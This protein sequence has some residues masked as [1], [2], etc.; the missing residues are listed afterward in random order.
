MRKILRLDVFSVAT[1]FAVFYAGIG[2]YIALKSVLHDE[3]SLLCPLGLELPVL[4][5][6]INITLKLPPTSVLV[7][8]FFVINCVVFY[9][10]T[11][12]LSG[13]FV[14]ILYNLTSR[15]WPGISGEVDA[16][17]QRT[18]PSPGI[19]LI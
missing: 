2:L 17:I 18:Q 12:A 4:H 8:P 6:T 11:G 7:T 14:S 1:L 19:G 9:A 16:K 13:T 15:F 10:I 3:S 5:F